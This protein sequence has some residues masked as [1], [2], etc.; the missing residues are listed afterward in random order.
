MV[1]VRLSEHERIEEEHFWPAVGKALPDGDEYAGKA[2]RQEQP[3]LAPGPA[4]RHGR[5]GGQVGLPVLRGGLR[6]ER[7][8]QGP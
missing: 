1:T 5:P 7:V 3:Q 4:D 6:P 8:R 2:L